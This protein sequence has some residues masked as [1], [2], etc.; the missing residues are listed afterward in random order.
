MKVKL[1]TAA[2]INEAMAQVKQDLGRDAVILH[3]RRLR[4]GG[5]LGLFAKEVVEVMAALDTAPAPLPV[6]K[7]P[8]DLPPLQAADAE[9]VAVAGRCGCDCHR[10]DARFPR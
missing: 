5:I 2:N 6:K 9:P 4:K 1:F 8:P 3:T 10:G 7:A